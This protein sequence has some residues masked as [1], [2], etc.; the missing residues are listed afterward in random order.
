MDPDAEGQPAP[1]PTDV[2]RPSL[3]DIARGAAQA[4]ER[5]AISRVLE[6]T[7]WNRTRAAKL[8]RISYRALL[9][10]IKHAG[11]DRSHAARRVS[12]GRPYQLDRTG[13][14]S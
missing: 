8:L 5:E 9:Y 6:E 10:K 4:A 1:E 12:A 3:K 2:P 7:G 11:L 13:V 14:V